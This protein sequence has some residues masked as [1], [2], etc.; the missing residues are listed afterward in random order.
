MY[1]PE[2]FN[3]E[4]KSEI[5]SFLKEY[6]FATIISVK[7]NF[8]SATHLPFVIREEN[9]A[10]YLISHF[11]KANE[12]W[13]EITSNKTLVIFNEPNAY[14]SPKNYDSIKNVP[15]WNYVSVHI[16]G[17]GE[18][19]TSEEET[20]EILKDTIGTYESDYLSQ[21]DKLPEAFKSNLIRGIVAFKIKVT[22]IQ[23]KKKA[24]QNRTETERKRIVE[25]LSKSPVE[26][27]RKMATYI[28]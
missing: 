2:H 19:I 5:I 7:D 15:T 25:N 13:K 28:K 24:S 8:P 9:N 27:E 12:Q 11:A 23:A 16:Y 14:I 17:Q 26:T 6:S 18:I 1:L 22:D 21:W 3:F 10:L 20:I 4:N